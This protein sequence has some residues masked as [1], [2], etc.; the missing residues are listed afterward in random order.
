MQTE[1]GFGGTHQ[2]GD[3]VENG[4]VTV[5]RGSHTLAVNSLPFRVQ[6]D[7]LGFGASK[8]NTK[9]MSHLDLPLLAPLRASDTIFLYPFPNNNN[10][11]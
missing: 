10:F 7:Y 2:P 1:F 8:V 3:Q 5:G 4:V 11:L 9:F 6:N